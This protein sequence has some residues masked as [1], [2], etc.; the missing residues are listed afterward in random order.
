MHTATL[1]KTLSGWNG[2]AKLYHLWPPARVNGRRYKFV[3]VSAVDVSR[4]LHD[5]TGITVPREKRKYGLDEET[6]VF[7]SNRKGEVYDFDEL[8]GSYRGGLDHERALWGLGYI[9]KKPPPGQGS[10]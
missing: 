7:G 5:M 4:V 8:P 1:F 9:I 3:I 2:D 10:G 6:Y